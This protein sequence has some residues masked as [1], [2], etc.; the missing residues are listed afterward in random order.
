MI[1]LFYGSRCKGEHMRNAW[2]V[3]SDVADVG[4]VPAPPFVRHSGKWV[5][6]FP[7]GCVYVRPYG[8]A[9][10]VRVCSMDRMAQGAARSDV[11][12]VAVPPPREVGS[13]RRY[14]KA[15]PHH[16]RSACVRLQHKNEVLNFTQKTAAWWIS[17]FETPF[18][19]KLYKHAR[20]YT[21]GKNAF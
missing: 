15:S 17:G 11:R 13:S 16:T 12:T 6:N 14:P 1:R 4:N 7:C 2:L 3:L 20:A 19:G 18:F 5:I 10:R 8:M 21:L 9:R